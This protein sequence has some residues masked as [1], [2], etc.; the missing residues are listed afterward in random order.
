M[1]GDRGFFAGSNVAANAVTMSVQESITLQ[2]GDNRAR[3]AALQC[4]AGSNPIMLSPMRV[5]I[6]AALPKA[7]GTEREACRIA[8]P[9][10]GAALAGFP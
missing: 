10:P 3:V 7:P 1:G 9:L 8:V 4:T 2:G 6:G 5:A